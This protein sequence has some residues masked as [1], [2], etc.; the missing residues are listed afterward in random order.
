[1]LYIPKIDDYLKI[2]SGDEMKDFVFINFGE[3]FKST[4]EKL[5]FKLNE[6]QNIR[7]VTESLYI[8]LARP[9]EVEKYSDIDEAFKSTHQRIMM[10]TEK[11]ASEDWIDIET[12]VKDSI[13]IFES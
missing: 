2:L 5:C 11:S 9:N 12:I 8:S 10:K 6:E 4:K 7:R 13:K 3:Y 1:M